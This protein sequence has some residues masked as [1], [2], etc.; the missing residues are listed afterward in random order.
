MPLVYKGQ[1]E[2]PC[3]L[4]GRRPGWVQDKVQA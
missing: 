1:L 3:W 2:P 4:Q